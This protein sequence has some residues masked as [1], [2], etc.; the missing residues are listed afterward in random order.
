MVFVKKTSCSRRNMDKPAFLRHY[1]LPSDTSLNI[2]LYIFNFFFPLFWVFIPPTAIVSLCIRGSVL[3]K[4]PKHLPS[5]FFQVYTRKKLF[6]ELKLC[7]QMLMRDLNDWS[8]LT[9]P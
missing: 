5:F 3:S 8:D 1:Q 6:T 4:R 2:P 7:C 9:H